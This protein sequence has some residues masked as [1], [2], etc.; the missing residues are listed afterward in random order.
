MASTAQPHRP[1]AP[2]AAQAPAS[3][4]ADVASALAARVAAL[5]ARLRDATGNSSAVPASTTSRSGGAGLSRGGSAGAFT[6]GSAPRVGEAASA[7][8]NSAGVAAAAL[9]GGGGPLALDVP[10]RGLSLPALVPTA[11]AQR[12]D[13]E[14][15]QFAGGVSVASAGGAAGAAVPGPGE[16]TATRATNVTALA[17]YWPKD[18]SADAA[19]ALPA[20]LQTRGVGVGGDGSPGGGALAAVP[21]DA[22]AAVQAAEARALAFRHVASVQEQKM[23][24][25]AGAGLKPVVDAM[26]GH[27]ANASVV[28]AGC[29][30]LR[31]LAAKLDAHDASDRSAANQALAVTVAACRSHPDKADVQAAAHGALRALAAVADAAD[32]CSAGLEAA[33]AAVHA[34]TPGPASV[35]EPCLR[36]VDD[37][38]TTSASRPPAVQAALSAGMLPALHNVM[39]S[40]RESPACALATCTLLKL[41]VCTPGMAPAVAS[42]SLGLPGFGHALMALLRAQMNDGGCVEVA[43]ECISLLGA[44]APQAAIAATAFPALDAVQLLVAALRA[45][46]Q[47]AGC[48]QHVS[49]ALRFIMSNNTSAKAAAASC[50]ALEAL[51]AAALRHP[52]SAAVQAACCGA[53]KS[54]AVDD[55]VRLRDAAEA[56]V[57]A[58]IAALTQH[59]RHNASLAED[60]CGALCNLAV[61]SAE[62]AHAV[63][64]AGGIAA[65]A[66]A[67]TAWHD[68]ADVAEAGCAALWAVSAATRDAALLARLSRDGGFDALV[69]ALQRHVD[70][71]PVATVAL[72][73]LKAA[74]LNSGDNQ[75]AV[76]GCGGLEAVIACLAH[77]GSAP[78]L[79]ILGFETLAAVMTK[80]AAIQ[81]WAF[82]AGA[83][84][85][86][87]AATE[88]RWRD[89]KQVCN[90]AA[91]VLKLLAQHRS[92]R[93]CGFETVN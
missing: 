35:L 91:K 48:A 17:Q 37:W 59:G 42:R 29:V 40:H 9:G 90:A 54:L 18:G 79:Q 13:A 53:L 81:R 73:A 26:S 31:S 30:A 28:T 74:C 71:A 58:L 45:Q 67:L 65:V 76:A 16:N 38:V 12:G 22:V 1:A 32:C 20:L 66:G 57:E 72:A 25:S 14:A 8:G 89:N 39:V 56:A 21:A 34:R 55:N 93:L 78:N 43:A 15:V 62:N 50:G 41:L 49:A 51:V 3:A 24:A 6:S 83:L 80:H 2:P 77:W 64:D 52:R 70:K 63:G 46:G 47:H 4:G 88:T 61:G 68:S 69:K 44:S 84:D 60:A 10:I 5:Q 85:V 86:V 23:R 92:G 11:A 87:T 7:V 33:V 36:S 82:Q 19:V 75:I 27:V